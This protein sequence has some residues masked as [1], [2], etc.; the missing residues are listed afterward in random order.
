MDRSD[1]TFSA[2]SAP[3]LKMAWVFLKKNKETFQSSRGIRRPLVRLPV[4]TGLGLCGVSRGPEHALQLIKDMATSSASQPSPS[5]KSG[6]LVQG[7]T[8]TRSTG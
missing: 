4:P 2:A 1:G 3:G 8:G 6:K 7:N 5:A